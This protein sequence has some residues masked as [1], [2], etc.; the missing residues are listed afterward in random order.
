MKIDWA[1]LNGYRDD[2]TAE[3]KL[4]LLE[5]S[6]A[7]V[8]KSSLDKAMSEAAERKRTIE[9]MRAE[10]ETG[11]S[12]H[13][14][15]LAAIR[16]ELDDMRHEKLISEYTARFIGQGYSAELAANAAKAFADG[17]SESVF[18]AMTAHAADEA[19]RLA[20]EGMRNTPVPPVGKTNSS[21][22][23]MD[24]ACRLALEIGKAKS[25]ADTLSAK[26]IESYIGG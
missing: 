11:E 19:K 25:A 17:D 7:Y 18:K 8:S 16:K 23:N 12:K 3:E 1:A 6:S 14:E 13:S 10:A 20:N 26:T 2:M 9:A 15:E 5:E 4:A 21:T 24:D 22:D